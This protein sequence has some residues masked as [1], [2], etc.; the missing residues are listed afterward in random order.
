MSSQRFTQVDA[1]TDRPFAGSPAAVFLLPSPRYS[2]WMQQVAQE[3]NLAETAF[4]VSRPDGFDLDS[5]AH[6]G[7]CAV[8]IARGE[9]LH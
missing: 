8:T 1:F 7:G 4:L 3:M 6:L 5:R 2:S 9:L